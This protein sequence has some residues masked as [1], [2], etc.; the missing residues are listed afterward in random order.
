[1]NMLNIDG[2]QVESDE[3]NGNHV[4]V[5]LFARPDAI[6]G[7]QFGGSFYHDKITNHDFTP[8]PR[9]GQSIVNAHIVYVGHGIEFLNE[10]FLIRHL[11]EHSQTVFNMPAFYSQFSKR[12]QKVSPFLGTSTRIRIRAASLKTYFCAMARLLARATTSTTTSRSKRNWIT[13]SARASQTLT[14][15]NCSWRSLSEAMTNMKWKWVAAL[16][17]SWTCVSLGHTALAQTGDVAVVVN[18]QNPAS[19][20]TIPELRKLFAG[21]KRSWAGG[22]SVKLIVRAPGT[23]E[24]EVLLKLLGVSESEYKQYWASRVMRGEAQSEPLVLP[25]LGMQREAMGLFDGGITLVAAENVKP[26]MKVV[27]VNGRMPGEAGYPLH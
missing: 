17:L 8:A 25:S 3:D 2:S 13:R 14:V 6:P 4:N 21:E 11:Q 12:F 19:N 15:C 5:G 1:M 24:R 7:L 27:K 10:G 20:L 16:I 22:L 26:G 9:L 18:P 23:H